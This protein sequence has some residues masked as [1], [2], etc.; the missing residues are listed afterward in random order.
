MSSGS[1][2]WILWLTPMDWLALSIGR[3]GSQ[4]LEYSIGSLVGAIGTGVAIYFTG[5]V[6]CSIIGFLGFM[7]GDRIGKVID[8]S[9]E[10]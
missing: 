4:P 10:E 6:W 1:A 7:I 2:C 9:K 5:S 3:S 8:D